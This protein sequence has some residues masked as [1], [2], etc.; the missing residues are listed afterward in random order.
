MDNIQRIIESIE[1]LE[2][3]S[4]KEFV[5]FIRAADSRLGQDQSPSSAS[6]ERPDRRC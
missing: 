6:A 5:E 2:G 4:E 1:G 3:V